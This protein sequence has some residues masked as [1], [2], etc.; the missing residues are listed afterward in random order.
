MPRLP[1]DSMTLIFACAAYVA[2]MVLANL[3]IAAFGPWISPLN[4]FLFIGLDLTLR[5]K[6]HD[7]W[8]ESRLELFGK[9]GLL[10]V[11]AAFISYGINPASANIAKASFFAFFAAAVVDTLAYH[12]LRKRG[13]MTRTNGSNVAGALTDSLL[14]PTLAFGSFLPHIVAMQF[15]AKVGGG[16]VWSLLL[17]RISFGGKHAQSI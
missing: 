9:M 14:F 16:Y 4:S 2:A 6:L 5:D 17:R 11:V 13:Y 10:I 12:L 15:F 8:G 7:L 3:S 1:G